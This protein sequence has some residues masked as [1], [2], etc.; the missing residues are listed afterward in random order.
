MLFRERTWGCPLTF[1]CLFAPPLFGIT[2]LETLRGVIPSAPLQSACGS[3]ACGLLKSF[4]LNLLII[5]PMASVTSFSLFSLAVAIPFFKV[6]AVQEGNE[7]SQQRV[8]E[9]CCGNEDGQGHWEQAEGKLKG[10]VSC[11]RRG[12]GVVSIP[13]RNEGGK[14]LFGKLVDETSAPLVLQG[15]RVPM[16]LWCRGCQTCCRGGLKK[17]VKLHR[18]IEDGEDRG[19]EVIS[20]FSTTEIMFIVDVQAWNIC[21]S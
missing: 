9:L 5:F 10:S 14:V 8:R 7:G 21:L 6:R 12:W 15:S 3:V 2:G 4:F 17:P 11:G 1:V 18:A 13:G 19:P 20:F 16:C